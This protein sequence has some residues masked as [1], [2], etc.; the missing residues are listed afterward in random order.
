MTGAGVSG[1]KE[2]GLLLSMVKHSLRLF[3]TLMSKIPLS[4]STGQS[5]DDIL[6]GVG[7]SNHLVHC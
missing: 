7:T 6:T 1:C 3:N 2:F 4:L 5:E